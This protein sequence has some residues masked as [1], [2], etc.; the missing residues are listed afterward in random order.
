[1]YVPGGGHEDSDEYLRVVL[2]GVTIDG[3][4]DAYSSTMNEICM[5]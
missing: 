3:V 4:N 1:M 5:R 2:I